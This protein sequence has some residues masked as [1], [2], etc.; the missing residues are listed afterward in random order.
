MNGRCSMLS[1][2]VHKEENKKTNKLAP[3]QFP[4]PASTHVVSNEHRS[5]YMS[6]ADVITRQC[7][8]LWLVER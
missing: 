8:K 6:N 3:V 7:G 5:I 1:R 4:I 2:V